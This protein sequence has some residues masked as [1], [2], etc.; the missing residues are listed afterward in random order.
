MSKNHAA[1]AILIAAMLALGAIMAYASRRA[2]HGAPLLERCAGAL[3][4]LGL[5]LLGFAFPFSE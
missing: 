4:V 3:L 1:L 2:S 5:V